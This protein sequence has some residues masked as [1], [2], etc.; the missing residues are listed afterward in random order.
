MLIMEA[1]LFYFKLTQDSRPGETHRP[2][3]NY[4]KNVLTGDNE[5]IR[6]TPK[7]QQAANR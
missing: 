2:T 3:D 6:A 4:E 7:L 5:E 1:V